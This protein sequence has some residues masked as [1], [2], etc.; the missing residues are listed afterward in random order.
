M[1]VKARAIN[2]NEN[3]TFVLQQ[4]EDRLAYRASIMKF[5]YRL[6][7]IGRKAVSDDWPIAIFIAKLHLDRLTRRKPAC[8]DFTRPFRHARDARKLFS[9]SLTCVRA[10]QLV[11]RAL[12]NRKNFISSCRCSN[13]HFHFLLFNDR[14]FSNGTIGAFF[15]SYVRYF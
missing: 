11:F 7:T 13:L 15:L 8:W 12:P 5:Y 3:G 10:R 2:W 14:A 4:R 9:R 1:Q 6:K